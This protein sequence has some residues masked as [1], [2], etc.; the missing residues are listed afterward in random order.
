MYIRSMNCLDLPKNLYTRN[1]VNSLVSCGQYM[2][3]LSGF[4]ENMNS[5]DTLNIQICIDPMGN[6]I[7]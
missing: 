4:I 2:Q 7:H 1:W 3:G 5:V 6:C